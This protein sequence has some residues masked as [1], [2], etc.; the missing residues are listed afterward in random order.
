MRW[1]QNRHA[2][3]IKSGAAPKRQKP[4]KLED[5]IH[6]ACLGFLKFCFLGM[7]Y[8]CPNGMDAGSEV[9]FIRGKAVPRAAIMWKK[10]VKL[11][12]RAGVLDLTLHW[13][14]GRTAYIEV[15]SADGRLTEG[16]NDFIIDLNRCGIPHVVVRSLDECI[17]AA[18]ALGLPLRSGIVYDGRRIDAGMPNGKA[19]ES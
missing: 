10:L 4:R 2:A 7:V 13:A 19:S 15:K 1:K 9:I 6:E 17:A 5:P 18:Y 3:W 16:Q 11:G 12:A 14:P 8:H